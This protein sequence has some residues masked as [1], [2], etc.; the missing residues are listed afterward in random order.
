M[1]FVLHVQNSIRFILLTVLC[2][3]MV[4]LF[5]WI[6]KVGIFD[7]DD[8]IL[9]TVGVILGYYLGVCFQKAIRSILI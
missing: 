6:G 7:I 2:I 5:Q 1:P 3:C 8:I 9:S 4:E